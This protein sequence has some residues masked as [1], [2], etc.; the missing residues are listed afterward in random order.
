[1]IRYLLYWLGATAVEAYHWLALQVVSS[2]PNDVK[3]YVDNLS[4]LADMFKLK[5]RRADDQPPK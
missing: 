1:M 3:G 5:R 2:T 4:H